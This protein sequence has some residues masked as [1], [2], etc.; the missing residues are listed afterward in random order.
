MSKA[1]IRVPEVTPAFRALFISLAMGVLYMKWPATKSA[2]GGNAQ[3]WNIN[4][5]DGT[6]KQA[7]SIRRVD[8]ERWVRRNLYHAKAYHV[9]KCVHNNILFLK[10]TIC[11]TNKHFLTGVN[12]IMLTQ[13]CPFGSKVG[14]Q[15]S[16]RDFRVIKELKHDLVVLDFPSVRLHKDITCYLSTVPF[17]PSQHA[18]VQPLDC[19]PAEARNIHVNQWNC[20]Q[21][22]GT[23]VHETFKDPWYGYACVDNVMCGTPILSHSFNTILGIHSAGGDGTNVYIPFCIQD[24]EVGL[25]MSQASYMCG[26]LDSLN[27]HSSYNFIDGF[28]TVMG[29]KTRFLGS[30]KSKL[31]RPLY[32]NDIYKVFDDLEPSSIDYVKPIFKRKP[33]DPMSDPYQINMRIIL[34]KK[35]IKFPYIKRAIRSMLKKVKPVPL[36][37]LSTHQAINGIDGHRHIHR[38]NAAT[39]M[40]YGYQG[41]KKDFLLLEGVDYLLP[42]DLAVEFKRWEDHAKLGQSLGPIFVSVL[43]DEAVLRSKNEIRKLRLFTS[44]PFLFNLLVRKYVLPLMEVLGSIDQE[45]AMGINCFSD[46]WTQLYNYFA[47]WHH[48]VMSTDYKKYDKNMTEE[49]ILADFEFLIKVAK[50][51]GYDDESLMVLK[52]IGSDLAHPIYDVKGDIVQ[53]IGSLV[54]GVSITT[55]INILTNKLYIRISYY[56]SGCLHFN[57]NIRFIAYGDD[58]MCSVSPHVCFN[59]IILRDTLIT[60]GLEVTDF[61]KQPISK[62]FHNIT[63]IE[64]LKRG[65]LPR[66]NICL[67]PLELT[68]IIKSFLWTDTQINLHEHYI[69]VFENAVCELSI[70]D[71]VTHFDKLITYCYNNYEASCAHCGVIPTHSDEIFSKRWENYFNYIHNETNSKG[72]SDPEFGN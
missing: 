4:V 56:M 60:L 62:P 61:D 20:K 36:E 47:P 16:Y 8:F 44:G 14:F 34:A 7:R 33:D 43:K 30:R 19:Q 55:L 22:D 9:D 58:M 12:N 40:G 2:H 70:H 53:V 64:F 13:P 71:S 52:V 11:I 23:Y 68:S 37:P 63:D 1:G 3:A 49:I 50:M 35:S 18:V 10:G 69:E 65:F 42:P 24:I 46:E 59:A 39:S 5:D 32:H 57:L 26:E 66:D 21:L 25:V 6:T 38:I 45:C 31:I 54:S 17:D 29:T 41:I 48:R 51:C 27:K 72:S 28:G 67:C 15:S